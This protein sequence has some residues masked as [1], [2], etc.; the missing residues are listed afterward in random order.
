[1]SISENP[2]ASP[3]AGVT[4]GELEGTDAEQIRKMYLSHEAS[5]QSIGLLYY[6]GGI[7]AILFVL[8]SAAGTPTSRTPSL[9]MISLGVGLMI[10]QFALGRGLRK[11][12]PWVKAP[13]GLFSAIGLLGFPVGT[14]V[15]AYILYLIFS[16]KGTMVFSPEYQEII[17]LTPHIRY[18]SSPLMIILLALLVAVLVTIVIAAMLHR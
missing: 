8:G 9:V 17:R 7:G 2:Y 11:L 3:V 14:V 1:M 18:R 16:R 15:S 12:R 13:V 5:V 4:A 6:L 10:V